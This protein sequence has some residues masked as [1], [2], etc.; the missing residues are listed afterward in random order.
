LATIVSQKV[1]HVTSLTTLVL[2]TSL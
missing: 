2:A 1:T